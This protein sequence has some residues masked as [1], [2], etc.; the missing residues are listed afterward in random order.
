ME[1]RKPERIKKSNTS[2]SRR[3]YYE[4]FNSVIESDMNIEE[5]PEETSINTI[6]TINKRIEKKEEKDKEEEEKIKSE[7]ENEDN[8]QKEIVIKDELYEKYKDELFG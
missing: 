2:N 3:Q 4:R 8:L 1:E 6:N 7:E 5:Q